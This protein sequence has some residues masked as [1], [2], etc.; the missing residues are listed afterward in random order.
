MKTY[1]RYPYM[2]QRMPHAAPLWGAHPL[3]DITSPD[4]SSEAVPAALLGAGASALN[5]AV[6]GGVAARSWMGAGVGAALSSSLWAGWTFV[7][8]YPL[9]GPQTKIA[10]GATAVLSTAALVALLVARSKRK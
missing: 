8:S 7:G 4:G 1:T 9:V 2:D 10:L 5:G 6:V 3:G